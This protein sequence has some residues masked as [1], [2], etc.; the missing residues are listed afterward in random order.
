MDSVSENK[1][2]KLLGFENSK[3]LAVVMI[4]S[5]GKVIKDKLD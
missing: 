1:R 4:V 2:Y 5:T 3:G